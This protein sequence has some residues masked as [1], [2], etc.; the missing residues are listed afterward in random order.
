MNER[1][2]IEAQ[3][4]LRSSGELPPEES[5]ALEAAL[6]CDPAAA[7]FARFV[8]ET[9]PAATAAPRD[10]AA[11]AIA[12]APAARAAVFPRL[13]KFTAAAAAMILATTAALHFLPQEPDG[14]GPAPPQVAAVLPRTTHHL[15]ARLDTI[16][17]ELAATRRRFERSRYHR[18][19]PI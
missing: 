17:D 12:A 10:F 7:A 4:L 6:A 11:L 3:L 16:E 14:S 19:P 8:E 13:W 9:L 15:S 5:A 18:P 2:R 1:N